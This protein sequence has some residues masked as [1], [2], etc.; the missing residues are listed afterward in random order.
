MH[1]FVGFLVFPTIIFLGWLYIRLSL[2][3]FL[4]ALGA[5]VMLWGT[6]MDWADGPRPDCPVHQVANGTTKGW[7]CEYDLDQPPQ[8]GQ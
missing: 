7:V 2:F 6:L 8:H 4:F 3:Q 1:D 5:A